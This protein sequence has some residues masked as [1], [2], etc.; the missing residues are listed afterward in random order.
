MRSRI[1]RWLKASAEGYT[2]TEMLVVIA[3]IGLIVAVV[4]PNLMGQLRRAQA[5]GAQVQLENMAS[6]IEMFRSDTGH[7]PK[8][9]EGEL[10]ALING[11]AIEGW[12]GPYIKD[13]KTLNDPWNRAVKYELLDNGQSF[14]VYS[15]GANGQVGGV[16]TDLDLEAPARATVS[17][18]PTGS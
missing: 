3:I 9:E 14:R 8:T 15:L 5:K 13:G 17:T 11:S 2:L 6:A 7:Y 4:T 10:K 12:T 16:G 1:S 18:A